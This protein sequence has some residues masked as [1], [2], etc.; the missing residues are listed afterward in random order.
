MGCGGLPGNGFI[1][2]LLSSVA[3]QALLWVSSRGVSYQEHTGK[4]L[5]VSRKL[6]SLQ[7]RAKGT[8][9]AS[10]YR[11]CETSFLG[12]VW[13]IVVLHS[14]SVFCLLVGFFFLEF[15]IWLN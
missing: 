7:R 11:N 9:V 12:T 15:L 6:C 1:I 2:I 14:L 8:V 5:W 4:Q 10:S 3:R 13:Y